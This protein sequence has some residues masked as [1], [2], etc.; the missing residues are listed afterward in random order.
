MMIDQRLSHVRDTLPYNESTVSLR[1]RA[2]ATK[3]K[4]KMAENVFIFYIEVKNNP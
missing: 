4:T 2:A 1:P 3:N